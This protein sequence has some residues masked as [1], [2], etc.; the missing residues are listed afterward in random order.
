MAAA[1]PHEHLLNLAGRRP[2]DVASFINHAACRQPKT[3]RRAAQ[4]TRQPRRQKPAGAST[5]RNPPEDYPNCQFFFAPLSR[6][7][8]RSH[9]PPLVASAFFLILGSR[10]VSGVG[11]HLQRAVRQRPRRAG[12]SA[13]TESRQAAGTFHAHTS[14]NLLLTLWRR[15][16]A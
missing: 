4:D 5:A 13:I 1:S 12:I 10:S 2:V 8:H 14:S 16:A 9:Y 11:E 6:P 15:E 3:R 7:Q